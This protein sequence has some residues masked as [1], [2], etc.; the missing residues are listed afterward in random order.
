[1][2]IAALTR[3]TNGRFVRKVEKKIYAINPKNR[4]KRLERV[5]EKLEKSNDKSYLLCASQSFG[6]GA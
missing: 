1:M 5:R 3:Q 6:D 4:L 2:I